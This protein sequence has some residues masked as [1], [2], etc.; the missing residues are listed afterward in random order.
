MHRPS[1]EG[2]EE[3][4]VQAM[5]TSWRRSNDGKCELTVDVQVLRKQWFTKYTDML[6]RVL[7]G[8]LPLREINHQ[9]PLIDEHKQYHYHLP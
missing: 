6:S 7:P 2:G 9:I 8:L 5:D 4:C 1:F 3:N